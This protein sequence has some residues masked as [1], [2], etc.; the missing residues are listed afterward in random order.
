M[1]AVLAL[2]VFLCLAG[3]FPQLQEPVFAYSNGYDIKHI[4]VDIT[5]DEDNTYHIV[6]TIDTWY[7]EGAGKHGIIR[8]LPLRNRI[9]RADGS[10]GRNRAEVSDVYVNAPYSVS[11]YTDECEIR[12]GSASE[13]I[14]GDMQYV[15]SY[16]YDIGPDRLSGADE[17]YFNIVGNDWD[18]TVESVSFAVH[19]PKE[20]QYNA[21]TLGFSHGYAGDGDYEGVI[22]K[23]EENTVYGVYDQPLASYQ[24]LT[25]RLTLPNRYFVR[26][27]GVWDAVMWVCRFV[28]FAGL[29]AML[30]IWLRRRAG[31]PAETVEFYPPDQ[32]DPLTMGYVYDG[33]V[34]RRD[35]TSLLIYLANLG[36]LSIR[37]TGKKDYEIVL[38]QQYTGGFEPARLFFNG[39]KNRSS[40]NKYDEEVVTRDRLKKHFYV[41]TD[42]VRAEMEEPRYAMQ[43]FL[44]VRRYHALALVFAFLSLCGG[45]FAYV[46][47]QFYDP[48]TAVMPLLFVTIM[49]VSFLPAF[50][51]TGTRAGKSVVKTFLIILGLVFVMTMVVSGMVFTGSSLLQLSSPVTWFAVG[52]AAAVVG[53]LL[54][55]FRMHPRSLYGKDLVSRIRGFRRFLETAEKDR[56]KMLAEQDPQYFYNILP[57][58]YVLGVSSKWIARF[59]EIAEAPPAWLQGGNDFAGA[60]VMD[61][62]ER[63]M[64]SFG[65]D[66]TSEPRAT[67]SG[68]SDSGGWSSSS[69]SD[70]SWSSS[71]SSG[72]GSSGGGSGGGGGSSW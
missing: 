11:H 38:Q 16:T 32:L 67:F 41:T 6:E 65:H 42:R 21:D 20:F 46:Y 69:S 2:T 37:E 27:G 24:G 9:Y 47:G 26:S 14:E 34:N 29:A 64:R 60:A 57:Y 40:K 58:A 55:G 1:T 50:L 7:E 63:S 45:V 18:T 25:M 33:K 19:F 72:G 8:R 4:D 59:D 43:F 44:P 15:I 70:S 5:V 3:C 39:L 49:T 62:I 54:I 13:T 61:T 10:T 48:W 28:P 22:Y 53:T 23:V 12:I 35:I 66:M 51:L 31:E 52:C 71:G 68:G 30:L 36:C 17:F 56:L